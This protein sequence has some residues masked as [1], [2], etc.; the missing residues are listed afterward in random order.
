MKVK[1]AMLFLL[2]GVLN[3]SFGQ[4][5]M[6]T[7]TGEASFFSKTPLENIEAHNQSVVAVLDLST[8]EVAVKMLIKQ[9]DFKKSLMQEHFN[10]NYMESDQFPSATFSGRLVYGDDISLTKSG[11]YEVK[12]VGDLDIHGVKKPLETMAT[13]TVSKGK[14]SAKTA[15]QVKTADHDIAIPKLVIKNIAET[16]D[17][18]LSFEFSSK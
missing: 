3:F 2:C 7:K 13:M 5:K 6:M 11:T 10:E 17:V 15:F 8:N 16:I 9:F 18:D 4:T 14:V 1:I 12:I